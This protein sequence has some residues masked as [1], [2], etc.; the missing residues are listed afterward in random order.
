MKTGDL[1]Y[2][3]IDMDN[4]DEVRCYENVAVG[5]VFHRELG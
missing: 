2:Y 4:N 3:V 5:P 1:D